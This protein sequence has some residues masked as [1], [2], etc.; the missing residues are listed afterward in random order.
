MKKIIGFIA[1]ITLIALTVANTFAGSPGNVQLLIYGGTTLIAAPITLSTQKIVFLTSLKYEYNAIETWL[2]NAEDLSSFVKEGQTLVFPEAGADPAV[3]KNRV[4]DIDDVEPTET[5]NEVELDTYD[6]QNYKLRNIYLHALPFDKVNFYTKK[7]ADALVRK[8]IADAAY[9]FAPDTTGNKKIIIP[10]TGSLRN[11]YKQMTLNDI[12]VMARGCDNAEFPEGRHLVLPS[13]MWWDLV[14]NNQILKGQLERMVMNGVIAPSVVEYYGFK[15]HKSLGNKLGV[16]WDMDNNVKAPQGSVIGG[17]IVPA[18]LLYC[19]GQVF[20]AGGNMEMFLKDKSVNTSGRAYEFGFQHRFKADFQMSSQRYSGLIYL[21]ATEDGP[22]LIDTEAVSLNALEL[23]TNM[24]ASIDDD[25]ATISV[26]Y[27]ETI[28]AVL[29]DYL[30]DALI[31]SDEL[32]PVGTQIA[33]KY[34]G[35]VVGTATI[36]TATHNIY[37]SQLV[38]L[39]APT[40]PVRPSIVI[41]AG[42]T[43]VWELTITPLAS[44]ACNITLNTLISKNAVTFANPRILATTSLDVDITVGA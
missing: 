19:E 33:I 40:A 7:S 43:A 15:I 44:L 35:S 27:P 9:T 6:S 25:K 26:Q 18:A 30:T 20:R 22:I 10:T 17:A 41:H 24:I 38:K 16:N 1:I 32:I 42:V 5:T 28:N 23:G 31:E 36:A 14:N 29:T 4:T 21:A 39:A 2:N 13:D 8:E 3:Y 34:N 11:G 12:V 37:L